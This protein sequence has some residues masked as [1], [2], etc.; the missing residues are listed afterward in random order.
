MKLTICLKLL[1]DASQV[2]SLSTLV[3][4]FSEATNYIAGLAFE[5]G[6]FTRKDVHDLCYYGVRD[7]FGLKANYTCQAI[8]QVV[9][10]FSR[11]K[12]VRPKFRPDGAVPLDT[13]LYRIRG[14]KISVAVIT[15]RTEMLFVCPDC[16]KP[17]LNKRIG[18]AQLV[19]RDG[20]FYLHVTVDIDPESAIIPTTSIGVDLGIV[21]IAT[22][23][24][25]E[26]FSG[27]QTKKHRAKCRRA[28]RTHQKRNTRNSKRRLRK[29]S[30]RESRFQTNENHRI[31][32]R[33]VSRAKA[34][35]AVIVLEDLKGIRTRLLEQPVPRLLKIQL[36]N[37]AFAH[38]RF[39]IQYKAALA[40]ISVVLVN[41][42]N[43][44]RTCSQCHYCDKKN[45]PTQ[46]KFKCRQCGY[47]GNADI[48]AAVN[49]ARI[50]ALATCPHLTPTVTYSVNARPGV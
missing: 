10:A 21:Q 23:S 1:P 32:K 34:L 27:E 48:N 42:R 41:P 29:I 39:C 40:G 26:Q 18:E 25:G 33:I 3:N 19:H 36:G 8:G 30:R 6:A 13:Q 16:H 9:A 45:R 5:A 24:E 49:I 12:T 2:E 4:T 35:Q 38:L 14:D 11:D 37:W 17:L 46:A 50:G 7:K 43:T 47:S 20:Q 28:R 31:A 44:S 15:G 22:T